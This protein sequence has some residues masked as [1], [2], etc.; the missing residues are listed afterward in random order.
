MIEALVQNDFDIN[1][2]HILRR[3]ATVTRKGEVATRREDGSVSHGSYGEVAR[4]AGK[5][6]N[7]L[8]GLGIGEGDR[9]ATFAWNSQ[10]HLEAYF[11]VPCMGAILHTLNI[12]LFVEQITYIVNHAEDRIIIVDDSLVPLIEP[13]ASTF[14]TV[15]HWIVIGSE[16]DPPV[17]LPN[18]LRY[19][20]LVDASSEEFEWPRI[21]GAAA[22]L[23]CYT[24]GTTGN[25]KGVLYGHRSTVLH[26]MSA[27]T[28]DAMNICAADRLLEIVPMFHA[29]AWGFPFICGLTGAA[30]VMPGRFLQAEPLIDLIEREKVTYAGA[31]P[32]IWMDVLRKVPE[33]SHALDSLKRVI[34]GGSA[35]SRGLMEGFETRFDLNFKQGYGMTETSPLVATTQ[36]PPGVTGEE[37]WAYK[38]KTGRVSPL[39]EIRIVDDSGAELPWDGEASG[40]LEFRGPWIASA[41]YGHPEGNDEKFHDGW[42]RSGDM[43]SI[44]PEGY[45]QITD[46]AKDVIKSGG[47]WI[48]SVDLENALMAHPQVVEAAVIAKP[49]PRWAERPLACVVC[50]DGASLTA[51]DLKAHLTPLVAKWWLPEDYA[52]I[53]EVP[54]TSVGKFDKKVLR[55]QLADGE[56]DV[57][58]TSGAAAPAS[59]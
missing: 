23:L 20:E 11:A 56:L 15:E 6:A 24:S 55:Q 54:K 9:V 1:I 17:S 35:V 25:P 36:T 5:L 30:Q 10:E 58:S 28:T 33:G 43:A 49:D 12:R 29:C 27:A 2:Q 40:E 45:I 50:E 16:S 19:H 47:E 37:M 14:N 22:G 38:M 41:Y 8:K 57:V 51:S 13:L 44:D 46:R 32:T 48:S 42:L 34:C 52:F 31:V 39:V 53:A 3:M 59:A 26:A 21:D 7:A 4:R 18:V